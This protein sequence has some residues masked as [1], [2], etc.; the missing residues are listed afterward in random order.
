MYNLRLVA[1]FK[2]E[3]DKLDEHIASLS[4]KT[5]ERL[6]GFLNKNDILSGNTSVITYGDDYCQIQIDIVRSKF[7]G[8]V[9]T[10]TDLILLD[11]YLKRQFKW[12]DGNYQSL[13]FH[14]EQGHQF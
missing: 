5:Q 6:Q 14:R 13:I 7:E 2:F 4:Q 9:P 10:L 12:K 11:L 3:M 1:I 8:G